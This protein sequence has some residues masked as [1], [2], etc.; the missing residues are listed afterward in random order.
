MVLLKCEEAAA[1]KFSVLSFRFE[2]FGQRCRDMGEKY[3]ESGRGLRE[4]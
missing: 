1:Q 4:E 2:K 3:Q